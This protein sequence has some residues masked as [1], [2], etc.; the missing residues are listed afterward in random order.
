MIY[1]VL[2]PKISS[3]AVFK[4][5]E[6]ALSSLLERASEETNGLLEW[7]ETGP[8]R[9]LQINEQLSNPIDLLKRGFARTLQKREAA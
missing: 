6:N 9:Q 7:R 5:D 3:L 2:A 4:L 1:V 8:L